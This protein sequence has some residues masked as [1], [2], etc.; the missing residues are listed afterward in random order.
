MAHARK[1]PPPLDADTVSPMAS[2]IVMR[3]L[4]KEAG[5][6]F[7]SAEE[8]KQALIECPSP[9]FQATRLN[10]AQSPESRS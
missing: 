1:S 3:C 6:R 4:E 10:A 7:Q 8:L 5:D 2:A 9:Q